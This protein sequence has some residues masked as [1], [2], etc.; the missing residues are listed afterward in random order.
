[1][2]NRPRGF[3]F[4]EMA[5]RASA[6]AAIAALNDSDFKGRQ[7]RV[8]ISNPKDGNAPGGGVVR[9]TRAPG[10]PGPYDPNPPR[11]LVGW[12]TQVCKFYP[13]GKCTYGESCNFIHSLEG[14]FGGPTRA[15]MNYRAFPCKH[16][17]TGFCAKGENCNYL[18][19]TNDQGPPSGY[20]YAPPPSAYYSQHPNY[21][22]P[23]SYAGY[24]PPYSTP[25]Q[26]PPSA[27]YSAYGASPHGYASYGSYPGGPPP[28]SYE[29]PPHV[30]SPGAV[31]P[32]PAGPGPV[33]PGGPGVTGPLS[34]G[35]GSNM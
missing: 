20:G 16:F 35:V 25:Y 33:G 12:K 14:E 9:S 6:N 4:V 24:P 32:G 22:A 34:P 17:Q 29:A 2:T 13:Q 28:H 11:G 8:S 19:D 18:H 3:A 26:P 5:T 1:M 30:T 21:S 23:P 31:G 15:S 7:L 10:A 27:Y